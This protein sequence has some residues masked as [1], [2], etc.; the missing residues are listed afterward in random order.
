MIDIQR[1]EQ[2]HTRNIV[3]LVCFILFSRSRNGHYG[4]Q[5]PQS[6]LQVQSNGTKPP[7]RSSSQ[8]SMDSLSSGRSATPVFDKVMRPPTDER[9]PPVEL[10]MLA[11][12]YHNSHKDRSFETNIPDTNNADLYGTLPRRKT[13]KS[14][15]HVRQCNNQRHENEVYQDFLENQR[16]QSGNHSRTGSGARTPVNEINSSDFPN[17]Y[18]QS[19]GQLIPNNTIN[20]VNRNYGE[21][22]PVQR[23]LPNNSPGLQ[24]ITVVPPKIVNQSQHTEV[25]NQSTCMELPVS[26]GSTVGF[27]SANRNY[28][29]EHGYSYC[30]KTVN[31]T[32]NQ[33]GEFFNSPP[34]ARHD[35]YGTMPSH[36]RTGKVAASRPL[37]SVATRT[38]YS[39]LLPVTSAKVCEPVALVPAT[40]LACAGSNGYRVNMTGRQLD[41]SASFSHPA[42]SSAHMHVRPRTGTNHT[43][44]Y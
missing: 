11:S 16:R 44:A 15:E 30:K 5:K 19:P 23:Y 25:G 36:M 7:S 35:L 2:I 10:H 4:Q 29:S 20:G 24:S 18:P 21:Q 17:N 6:H 33:H 3:K 27:K 22:A 12:E 42:R 41:R 32:S 8:N 14:Q 13:Q 1:V 38:A 9:V 40:R 34:I 37:T 28:S 43:E 39:T 26:T 31:D